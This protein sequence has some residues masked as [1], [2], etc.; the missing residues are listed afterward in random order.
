VPCAQGQY[1][2][3]PPAHTD[4]I[5][6][7][8]PRGPFDPRPATARCA[9]GVLCTSSVTIHQITYKPGSWIVESADSQLGN[10][11]TGLLGL[12]VSRG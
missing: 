6:P 11:A 5:Q 3:T 12:A 9:S 10:G 1:T 8:L 7:P 2:R 4:P